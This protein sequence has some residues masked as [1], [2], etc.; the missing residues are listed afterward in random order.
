MENFINIQQLQ[1]AISGRDCIRNAQCTSE[2]KEK[3]GHERIAFWHFRKFEEICDYILKNDIEKEILLSKDAK[4]RL[5]SYL[6]DFIEK[7]PL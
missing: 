1:N 7:H 4:D 5:V 6:S 2:L 3:Y